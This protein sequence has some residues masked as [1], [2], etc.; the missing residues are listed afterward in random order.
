VRFRHFLLKTPFRGVLSSPLPAAHIDTVFQ[1]RKGQSGSLTAPQP[2]VGK[3]SP[4][5]SQT[6]RRKRVCHEK[7]EVVMRMP[8]I[9]T[10]GDFE[11]ANDPHDAN[12]IEKPGTLP[13]LT[14][15]SQSSGLTVQQIFDLIP[16]IVAVR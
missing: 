8:A 7:E 10:M 13:T 12:G 16:S 1:V 2:V 14:K 15:L 6:P 9:A 5:S 11:R 4:Q 3:L